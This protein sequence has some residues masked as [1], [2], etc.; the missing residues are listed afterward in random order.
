M[1][2]T[3]IQLPDAVYAKAK[4]VA[5]EREL[6]LAEM[7]RR[8]LELYFAQLSEREPKPGWALPVA[9][10]GRVRVPLAELREFA[11]DDEGALVAEDPGE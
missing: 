8:G 7:V 6:S 9:E 5:E 11:A 3:Q 4:R 10:V 1:I 2:R